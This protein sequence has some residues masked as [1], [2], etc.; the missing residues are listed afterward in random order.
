LL[1]DRDAD[2]KADSQICRHAE[3]QIEK[4]TGRE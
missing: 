2:G 4:Q 3:T 1:L